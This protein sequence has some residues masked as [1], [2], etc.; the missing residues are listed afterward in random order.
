M[1]AGVSKSTQLHFLGTQGV[2]FSGFKWRN[3]GKV[4]YRWMDG[5][6]RPTFP[7]TH[8]LPTTP[9]VKALE[10]ISRILVPCDYNYKIC[11]CQF[12]FVLLFP[13]IFLE[14]LQSVWSLSGEHGLDYASL[15]EEN[16]NNW[17]KVNQSPTQAKPYNDWHTY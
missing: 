10:D 2:Y 17:W 1:Q 9:F 8:I 11:M 12:R 4:D 3:V 14:S 13:A 16:N 15:C 5:G 6:I 7:N